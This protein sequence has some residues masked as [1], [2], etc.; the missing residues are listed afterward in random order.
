MTEEDLSMVTTDDLRAEI[1]RRCNA[2]LIVE[3]HRIT[4]EESETRVFWDGGEVMSLGL[5]EYARQHILRQNIKR[6]AKQSE[7]A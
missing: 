7:D 1:A 5:A 2:C 4:D 3:N 6:D